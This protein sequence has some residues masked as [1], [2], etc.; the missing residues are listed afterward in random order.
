MDAIVSAD[1]YGV[2][3]EFNAAA[4]AMFGY[5]R[6]EA[7]GRNLSELIIPEAY[8][9]RH[10]A[11]IAKTLETGKSKMANR[12]MQVEAMRAD[13][14]IF[15]VELTI[16]RAD[17][18]SH[19]IFVGEMRDLTKQRRDKAERKQL[20][21]VLD[22]A[23]RILPSG[24]AV[25]GA[26]GKIIHCNDAFARPLGARAA[27]ITGRDKSDVFAELMSKVESF[28]EGPGI[29]GAV[30]IG[31]I[32]GWMVTG[33]PAPLELQ[34][35]DGGWALL[36]CTP[37]LDGGFVTVLTDV[38]ALK[39][40][41]L[42]Q[43]NTEELIRHVVENSPVPVSMVRMEDAAIIYE[44]PAMRELFGVLPE[45]QGAHVRDFAADAAE[46]KTLARKLLRE[47]DIDGYEMLF[48]KTD[49]TEFWGEISVRTVDYHG[50][51]AAVAAIVDLTERRENEEMIR[52][53][54]EASPAPITMVGRDDGRI[55]YCSPAQ[56][57]IFGLK[58]FP[59][60]MKAF[61]LYADQA[62]RDRFIAE[63]KR[64]GRIDGFE[65][66]MKRGDG[67]EFWAAISARALVYRGRDVLV[68]V[69]QDMTDQLA[70]EA[71]MERQ[72][73]ALHQREKLS[74]LGEVL[75][76]VAHELNNPLS[77]VVGQALM[78]KETAESPK[79]VE[80]ARKISEAADRCARIVKT[81]LAMA[82]QQP[83]ESKPVDINEVVESAIEVTGYSLR[84]TDI[85]L[86]LKLAPELPPVLGDA[87]Q[88]GQVVTNLLVN[89]QQALEEVRSR[90]RVE[91]S[92][93]FDRREGT[94]AITIR[95]NGP[96]IPADLKARIFEPLFTT[97]GVGSGT[98]IGLALCNRI[99]EVHGGKIKLDSREGYGARFD[100]HLPAS[101]LTLREPDEIEEARDA[102]RPLRT[103]V[104]DDEEDVAD[105]LA[106]ILELAGYEVMAAGSGAEAL[107]LIER[108]DFDVVLSD[109]RMPH[110]DGPALYG[111]LR[112]RKPDLADRL[113]FV[114][115]DTM[116]PKA[117]RFLESTD[118]PYIKKPINP[119]EVRA[120]VL[121]LLEDD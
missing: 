109:V 29:G 26:N 114:T 118:R 58:D 18:G 17:L 40:A 59:E 48:R 31:D 110:L 104:I 111:I 103:L 1:E 73:D 2:V 84:S 60:D 112:E 75:A 92:T 10:E 71:E 88:L 94:V 42:E 35:D 93:E 55:I 33:T 74:A 50:E 27:D 20:S 102:D 98:G 115:G 63:L 82:R 67:S 91:V 65:A 97:K 113:A 49:G 56:L 43:R 4:E 78:L 120:L 108:E 106:E 79:N 52:R 53:I 90:R 68:S 80:R 101:T 57:E 45:T 36:S 7:V 23:L 83:A 3:I 95:D 72:R 89:A 44:S 81:F 87:S 61:D 51:T 76:G 22:N 6:K 38:T 9:K 34:W 116:S 85:D 54:L 13:G 69:T 41:E 5:S 70:V 32:E 105:L 14:S 121:R 62:D 11:G 77:V 100:I 46:Q 12:R 37:T 28:E 96:G 24:L 21:N 64:S 107:R 15:P 119:Q 19:S 99:V 30:E 86:V 66:R 8:R 25:T 39:T 117:R 16:G 47:G